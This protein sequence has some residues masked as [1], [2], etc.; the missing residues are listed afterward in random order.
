MNIEVSSIMEILIREVSLYNSYI[1]Q[2]MIIFS[3]AQN[4][5]PYDEYSTKKWFSTMKKA[6]IV[7]PA[8]VSI[9]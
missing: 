8:E 9:S 6:L 1:A 4:D 2:R 3:P 7:G 5:V